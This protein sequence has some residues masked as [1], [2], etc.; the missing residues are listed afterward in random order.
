MLVDLNHDPIEFLIS[1][2]E[3][4]LTDLRLGVKPILE[5]IRATRDGNGPSN[6][7]D[8]WQ[9]WILLL[10]HAPEYLNNIPAKLRSEYRELSFSQLLKAPSLRQKRGPPVTITEHMYQV[11]WSHYVWFYRNS[12]I[13]IKGA[14]L[15]SNVFQQPINGGSARSQHVGSHNESK[16][17]APISS[18]DGNEITQAKRIRQA[19]D[20]LPKTYQQGFTR[21]SGGNTGSMPRNLIGASPGAN[22]PR[23]SQAQLDRILS[24]IGQSNSSQHPPTIMNFPYQ[25]P[26]VSSATVAALEASLRHQD[27]R[28]PIQYAQASLYTLLPSRPPPQPKLEKDPPSGTRNVFG[29]RDNLDEILPPRAE[30]EVKHELESNCTPA[31]TD[32]ALCDMPL[33]VEEILT[34]FP[35]HGQWYTI[36]ARL[37]NHEW[38][39]NTSATTFTG[40]GI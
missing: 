5:V 39:R 22:L 30:S 32:I 20:S 13:H 38:T 7:W 24:V 25:Q 23:L 14:P 18:N 33:S 26:S 36:G 11:P 10:D 34:Y 37:Q 12:V 15:R 17:R 4:K 27:K 31:Q 8:P 16:R 40:L 35:L 6:L 1:I 28:H 29:A 21:D 9:G 2:W 19:Q 3:D